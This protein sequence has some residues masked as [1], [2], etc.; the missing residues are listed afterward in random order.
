MHPLNL[1]YVPSTN[2]SMMPKR[3]STNTDN[4][5]NLNIVYYHALKNGSKSLSLI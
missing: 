1:G 4:H 2:N 5:H 3:H